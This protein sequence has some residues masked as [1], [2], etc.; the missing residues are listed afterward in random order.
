M[1]KERDRDYQVANP[2]KS[3]NPIRVDKSHHLRGVGL[4]ITK[5]SVILV[6]KLSLC[7]KPFS[8]IFIF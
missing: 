3:L 8:S 4:S 1:G 7:G 5:K 2:D 6:N